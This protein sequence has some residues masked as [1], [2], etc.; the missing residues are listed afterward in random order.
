[1]NVLNGDVMNVI[2]ELATEKD[3]INALEEEN[4][5]LILREK[6]T[7]EQYKSLYK[8]YTQSIEK[9]VDLNWE[10]DELK[11]ELK[12]LKAQIEEMNMSAKTK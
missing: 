11:E 4:K 2:K 12:E 1:M 5:K 7:F 3:K 10:I 8:D 9:E 6:D